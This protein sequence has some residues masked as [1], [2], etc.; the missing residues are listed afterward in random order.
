MQASSIKRRPARYLALAVLFSFAGA[1]TC[2]ALA[3]GATV[4]RS[5]HDFEQKNV[6][7]FSGFVGEKAS[8]DLLAELQADPRIAAAWEKRPS[9][10]SKFHL[11]MPK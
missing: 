4:D 7:A 5:I 1:L 10:P 3:I 8:S 11:E 2:A 9:A 6:G